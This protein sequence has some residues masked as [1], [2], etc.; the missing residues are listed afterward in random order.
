V[1]RFDPRTNKWEAVYSLSTKRFQFVVGCVGNFL[2]AIGGNDGHQD[3][4]TAERYSPH[5][6]RWEAIAPMITKRSDC[7]IA[8][9]GDSIYL[10]GG[11]KS[12]ISSH[13]AGHD[14]HQALTS[15]ERYD[16]RSNRWSVCS[17]MSVR[18]RYFGVGVIGDCI[19]L[20]CYCFVLP[21][22]TCALYC[23]FDQI[24]TPLEEMMVVP[25]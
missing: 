22:S 14:G 2:Y 24:F 1:E 8:V 9:V 4:Q 6:N 7:G 23:L 16:T 18:R 12:I 3:L 15:M 11:K 19:F 25:S 17:P 20:L 13:F 21:S 10:L 5:T